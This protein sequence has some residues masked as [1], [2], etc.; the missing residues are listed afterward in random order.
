ML[1]EWIM[2]TFE[3]LSSKQPFGPNGR[4]RLGFAID[5]GFCSQGELKQVFAQARSNGAHLITCHG[6]EVAMLS[7]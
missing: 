7:A 6:T 1:P 2:S 4:V 3:E 5:P